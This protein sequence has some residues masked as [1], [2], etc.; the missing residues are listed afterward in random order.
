[1]F[2]L[3][4]VEDLHEVPGPVDDVVAAIGLT[5]MLS[6]LLHGL[7]ARPAVAWL[8]ANPP[9]RTEPQTPTDPQTP[10]G[11]QTPTDF[12]VRHLVEPPR[13]TRAVRPPA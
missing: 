5:I 7:T 12:P 10:T 1:V 6:V 4:A 13:R 9:V 11:L 3:I 2:A 8:A